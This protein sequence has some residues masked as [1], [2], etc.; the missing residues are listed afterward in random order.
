[1]LEHSLIQI[2]VGTAKRITDM[3]PALTNETVDLIDS[4]AAQQSR[5]GVVIQRHFRL[6]AIGK[7]Q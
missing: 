7:L 3:L 2:V 4:T 5:A 1:M 6:A